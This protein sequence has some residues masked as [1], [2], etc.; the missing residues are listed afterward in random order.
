MP[1][2]NRWSIDA[3]IFDMDGLLIDSDR[4][5]L[6]AWRQTTP[7]IFAEGMEFEPLRGADRVRVVLA[8]CFDQ[9]K[10]RALKGAERHRPALDPRLGESSKPSPV[11]G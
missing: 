10:Q 6:T 1:S 4:P 11:G 5:S 2:S 9:D 8:V 7:S 3:A